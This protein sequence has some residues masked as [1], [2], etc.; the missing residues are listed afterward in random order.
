[1][2]KLGQIFSTEIVTGT[3]DGCKLNTVLVGIN[4]EFFRCTNCGKDLEQKVNGVIKYII[5]NKNT[6]FER[7]YDKK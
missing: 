6:K 1:M 4:G 2:L 3:C 7:P 5:A